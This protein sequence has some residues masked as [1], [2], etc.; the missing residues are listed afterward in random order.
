MSFYGQ[1]LAGWSFVVKF[2]GLECL[3]GPQYVLPALV[4]CIELQVGSIMSHLRPV[5][6]RPDLGQE[7]G[8]HLKPRRHS[9]WWSRF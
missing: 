1:R 5:G 8:D 4:E 7:F 3:G 2:C 9:Q 6:T